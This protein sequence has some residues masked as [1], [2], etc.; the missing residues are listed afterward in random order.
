MA[1]G[2]DWCLDCGTAQPGRLGV[3]PGW[4]AAL[5]VVALTGL[6]VSGAVAASYAA[7]SSEAQRDASAPAPP[8]AAPLVA[9]AP[10]Q[11]PADQVKPP[12]VDVPSALNDGGK[13]KA[14]ASKPV[15]KASTPAPSATTGGTTTGGGATTTQPE[16]DDPPAPQEI[17]LSGRHA[18]TYDPYGNGAGGEAAAVDGRAGTAWTA[19]VDEQGKVESGLALSFDRARQLDSL[20]LRADTPGFTVEIYATRAATLPPNVL[21]ARWEH[22]A[23]RRDVGVRARAPLSGRFRHVLLWVTEQPADTQVSIAEV[24]L[25][26]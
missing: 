3:R 24:S 15:P 6:L 26:G 17:S 19:Q 5:T 25:F 9:Q 1:D 10:P 7:L 23:D 14:P 8:S 18:S 21:D 20:E 11:V 16:N 13:I 2:Q 12:E 4:R 22:V